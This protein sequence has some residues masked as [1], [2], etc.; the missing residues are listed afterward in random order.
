MRISKERALELGLIT[1]ADTCLNCELCENCHKTYDA[2]AIN[3]TMK[4]NNYECFG[5]D[6]ER[7]RLEMTEKEYD[8]W[9]HNRLEWPEET[10]DTSDI[11]SNLHKLPV[12]DTKDLYE[13]LTAEQK[14]YLYRMTWYENVFEDITGRLLDR[15]IT[16][17]DDAIKS[18]VAHR[19]VYE[20]DYDCNL[21]YWDN[22]DNLIDECIKQQGRTTEILTR[23]IKNEIKRN[24]G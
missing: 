6:E 4:K 7:L 18:T 15:D 17:E 23:A 5:I 9:R 16:D 1:E 14:D 8:A 3:T 13:A 22:I 2:D 10:N 19:Y 24:E 11:L 20:G 21:S 12:C